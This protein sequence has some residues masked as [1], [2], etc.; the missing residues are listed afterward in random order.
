MIRQTSLD[1][2]HELRGTGK[3]GDRQKEVFEAFLKYGACTD[4]ELAALMHQADPN[5]VRPRRNELMKLGLVREVERRQCSITKRRAIV[6][7]AIE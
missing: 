6:W 3:L 7:D 4:R 5:Q 2:Y 1:A